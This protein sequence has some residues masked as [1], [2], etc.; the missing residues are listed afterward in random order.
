[1]RILTL[2]SVHIVGLTENC[3]SEHRK[4]RILSSDAVSPTSISAKAYR[5]PMNKVSTDT[6]MCSGS[7]F[8]MVLSAT[9]PDKPE[10]QKSKIAREQVY[11]H[12]SQVLVNMIYS[13]DIKTDGPCIR[14]Q[15][16]RTKL[17]R[18]LSYGLHSQSN[19]S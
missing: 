6:P 15:A 1:M 19:K 9:L 12:V 10:S 13:N 16:T 7:K 8:S 2:S 3:T 4:A 11:L 14:G 17:V 5:K 18:I